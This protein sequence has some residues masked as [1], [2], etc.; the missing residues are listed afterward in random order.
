MTQHGAILSEDIVGMHGYENV[1]HVSFTR[2]SQQSVILGT[3]LVYTRTHTHTQAHIHTHTRA[4]ARAHTHTH[5]HPH[6]HTH[7]PGYAGIWYTDDRFTVF[8]THLQ[9]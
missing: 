7:T 2:V 9:V 6:T 3:D 8:T 5:T 4:R 1:C